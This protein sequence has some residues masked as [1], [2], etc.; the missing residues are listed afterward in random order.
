[1]MLYKIGMPE[2]CVVCWWHITNCTLSYCTSTTF[3]A[4]EQS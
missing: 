4:C 1:M 3:C 2:Y